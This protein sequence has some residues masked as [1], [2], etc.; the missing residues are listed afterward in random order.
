[1]V[2][3]TERAQVAYD[4]FTGTARK[5]LDLRI[6]ALEKDITLPNI[7]TLSSPSGKRLWVAP[8]TSDLRLIYSKEFDDIIILDILDRVQY[9]RFK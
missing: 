7:K 3:F 8:V 6:N 1:M 4:Q 5:R 9:E 2:H